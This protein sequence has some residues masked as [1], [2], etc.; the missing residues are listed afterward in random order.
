MYGFRIWDL[1]YTLWIFQL[2]WKTA[3]STGQTGSILLFPKVVVLLWMSRIKK[4]KCTLKW[5][6]PLNIQYESYGQ[7]G[8]IFISFCNALCPASSWKLFIQKIFQSVSWFCCLYE[9]TRDTQ[10]WLINGHLNCI[11]FSYCLNNLCNL[12]CYSWRGTEKAIF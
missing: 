10:K 12:R 2:P 8:L 7:T 6:F 3:F 4:K 1:Y 5:V 11:Y 9:R